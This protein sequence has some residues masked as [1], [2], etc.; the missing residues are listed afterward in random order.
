MAV[1][2]ALGAPGVY[3]EPAT[4]LHAL[5]GVRMDVAGFA[6]VAPRGPVRVPVVD[7]LHGPGAGMVAPGRPRARSVAVPVQSWA[8]YRRVFGGF[9]G[10]GRLPWSVAAFF[11]QGGRRAW[12]VRVVHDYGADVTAAAAGVVALTL[13]HVSAPGE[14]AVALH[15][16]SEGAW[17]NTLRGTLR[18][19]TSPL[20][21][22]PD[23]SPPPASGVVLAAG[24]HEVMLAPDALV[25]AG[26]LLR[27]THELGTRELRWVRETQPRPRPAQAG[28][29]RYAILELATTAAAVAVEVV[30]GMLEL[31][32][33]DGRAERFERLGLRA[34]HPRWLADVLC[35]E[36]A[37]AWPDRAWAATEL[38][39][40]VD[41]H[42]GALLPGDPVS[43]RYRELV[44][45]DMFDTTWVP[46]D[47][48]DVR[49]PGGVH[50]LLE[51][52]EV[53]SVC[54]PDLYEP[55]LFSSP[56]PVDP[57]VHAAGPQFERCLE[58][59]AAST[60]PGAVAEL[61]GLT[62][63]PGD[64]AALEQIAV[65]QN[66]LVA[67]AE[68]AGWS[69]LLD[70]PPGLTRRATLRWR[71]RFDSARAAAYAPWLVMH[72]LGPEERRPRRIPP[73]AVAAGIVAA[74]ELQHG[75]AHGPAGAIAARVVAVEQR[76]AGAEHDE[77]HLAG[78]NVFALERDG[79]RL[80]AARTLSSDPQW[81][82]LSVRRLVTMIARALR[83]Q[84]AWTVFESADLT[85][86][87]ELR[88]VLEAFL[89]EL[90]A[91]GALAGARPSDGYFVRCDETNNPQAAIDAGRLVVDV[92]VAPVE[93]LEYI[94]LRL[95]RSD[96]GTIRL[97]G[98]G[99]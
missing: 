20:S 33:G 53:A 79:V 77:L 90:H 78:I 2:V 29:D 76:I 41:L 11:A 22:P 59:A 1:R 7:E 56:T 69:A 12:V 73:S 93:P 32:D 87:S 44:P 88:H 19:A 3:R 45:T 51:A 43:D 92:G 57:T 5:T 35:D 65:L 39:P 18:F 94:V 60:P 86:R 84:M 74:V 6:G 64:P 75:I 36:S 71:A 47:E 42:D 55:E 62:M 85:L 14:S 66:R 30:H 72:G 15:A 81:R 91:R 80:T 95:E 25:P 48:P 31:D 8:D 98:D 27:I 96:D 34:G 67:L 10:P 40:D 82:Q 50:A 17:A 99:G 70:V 13:T 89:R 52:D 37:L 61:A 21:I 63:D 16:R 26:S 4:P 24:A 97:E 9:E 49:L 58:P 23:A 46:G 28:S 38:L 83:A 54:L 68:Y